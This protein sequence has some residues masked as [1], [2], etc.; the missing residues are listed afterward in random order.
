MWVFSLASC[1]TALKP[2]FLQNPLSKYSL[3]LPSS[4]VDI[5]VRVY[6]CVFVGHLCNMCAHVCE[7]VSLCIFHLTLLTPHF[8]YSSSHPSTSHLGQ[9][10]CMNKS[11]IRHMH[12]LLSV[13]LNCMYKWS[14]ISILS[15]V[16]LQP[17]DLLFM[18][19]GLSIGSSACVLFPG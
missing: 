8:L 14:P 12:T 11:I 10:D 3:S 6:I 18:P 17:H 5:Y 9:T 13:P 16:W 15:P 1:T 19:S 7:C 4:S 2:M